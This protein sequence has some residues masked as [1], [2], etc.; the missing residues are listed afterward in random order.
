[1]QTDKSVPSPAVM[2]EYRRQLLEMSRHAA[3]IVE[4]DW[5][6][7][8]YPEPDIE[9]DKATL[10]PSVEEPAPPIAETPFVGYLRIFAFTAGEAEPIAGAR[11]TVRR[12]GELYA[13]VSTNRDGYTPVIPLPTVDP[14]RSL[15]PGG[16]QPFVPYDI[17]VYADG[18]SPV[19]HTRV[20][21]YGNTYSTQP[22]PLLPLLPNADPDAI[23]K[24][25]S[26]GPANL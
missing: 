21:I 19:Q 16:P 18:F 26:D 10:F 8:R 14:A 3:P 7:H 9:Q 13:N 1:M 17:V 23:Q 2:E 25:T 22:I 15:Q 20:P 24:F 5:L 6:D 12:D 4:D 11:V